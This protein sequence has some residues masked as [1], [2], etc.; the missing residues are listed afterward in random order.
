MEKNLNITKARVTSKGYLEVT[1]VDQNRNIINMKGSDPVHIDM[2]VVLRKLVPYMADVTEQREM[3]GY[4]WDEP[5]DSLYN[6][7]LVGRMNVTGV[8]VKG[9]QDSREMILTG[10]RVL[11]INKVMGITT[12]PVGTSLDGEA[13][14]R[15]EDMRDLVD[16]FFYEVNLYI[17]EKKFGIRQGDLDFAEGEDPFDGDPTDD[18]EPITDE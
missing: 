3:Q 15:C 6:D 12:P 13:Y 18:A 8:T 10:N 9:Y 17:T 16:N 4:R 11:G 7:D 5:Y 1:Y 2:K 14:E